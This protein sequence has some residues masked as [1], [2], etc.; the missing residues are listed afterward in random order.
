MAFFEYTNKSSKEV[1]ELFK[2]SELGL[3]KKDV[4]L[5]Q[6]KY[7]FNE[8]ETKNVNAFSVLV[9]QFKSPFTYLLLAAAIISIF[10]GQMVDSITVLSFIVINVIIGFF[11]EYKAEKSVYFLQKF[12][13][14]KV[15]V[16]RASKEEVIDRKFLVP[17]DIVL[18]EAG[19]KAPADLRVI[20]LHNFLID[21]SVLTGESA[22]VAKKT[23]ATS[24][25]QKEIFMAE[26][27]IFSG[28]SVISGKATAV[29][30]AT[31]RET[32][33]GSVVKSVSEIKKESA[34]EKS[35]LYFSKLILR[36]VVTTIILIFV[37]NILV[38]GISD[39]FELTLFAV[40][41][42]VSILP[43]ALPAVVTFSLSNGSMRMAKQNVVVKRLS[44][45]EDLGNI[46]VLC[47][48]KTGT[49]TQNKLTLEKIVSSDKKKSLLYVALSFIDQNIKD[50]ILNPFDF[51]IVQ[52]M[53]ENIFKESK[54]FK[55]ISE[56]PFDSY[57]MRAA[58]LA[59]PIRG[60]K[61]LIVKGAAESILKNCSKSGGNL[62]KAE[63]LEDIEREGSDGKRVLA[64][65]FKKIG[66][67][68]NVISAQDEKGLTF[69]GYFVFED[70][71]KSTSKEALD[72][73]KK[74]GVK[75]K[76]ITGDSK[77]V[78]AWVAKK[79]G[80]VVDQK[81]IIS[82]RELEVL[83]KE[84]FQ[85]ACDEKSVFV[86]ISPDI[87]HKIIKSLQVKYDVGFMGEGVND[88]PALKVADVGIAVI[89][90]SDVARE[91]SDVVLLQ[92]DLRVVVNGIKDGRMIFSNIN[93]YIKCALASNFGNFYSIAAISVFINFLPMLPV[94]ILLGN[95]LSD[96]PLIS[97]ATDSVDIEELRKPKLYQLHMVLPLIISLAL[98]STVFDFIFFA[99]FFK[100]TPAVIQTLWYIESII[101]EI[102]LIFIIRTRK[103]FYKAK[104]PSFWLISL[105]IIDA[106]I[107]V[108]LPFSKIG[109]NWFHF[110]TPPIIPLLIV[111][112]LNIAY[113]ITSELVKLIYFRYWKPKTLT[114]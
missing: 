98:V 7:G 28:T 53:P 70:P 85:D 29:V 51:A 71:V 19:D 109:Q 92:K 102:M 18:L 84:E 61:I 13:P 41:L 62:D 100:Q 94:Q 83:T 69:L 87:K 107:V 113:F 43:E 81:D 59:Q 80:L 65:A 74:L 25:E 12:I 45:I 95:I 50:K 47:T 88:A 57:R 56:L 30:I 106:I 89:E 78:T 64:I 37:A 21:E 31:G 26:N 110:I 72:L 39:F 77:E 99:I 90:A 2:T 82:G 16:L 38:K 11:Q 76:I 9:R 14:Q 3:L 24:K 66:K 96:F 103:P 5:A 27:I 112:G 101:T 8:I 17:G 44:A 10:V 79:T 42:I 32:V 91:A 1:L 108:V 86:R 111:F 34:Y 15:K 46:E 104:R 35:I 22:P 60:D 75:V 55:I 93:K 48:D 40:A 6:E 97:V 105:A 33:F 4:V 114:N 73:A 52:R 49:L 23:E 67:D 68:Q 63:I 36:I 58:F 20:N 54:N